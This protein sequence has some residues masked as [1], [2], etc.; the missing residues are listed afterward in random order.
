MRS[1]KR[2]PSAASTPSPQ[3]RQQQTNTN[4]RRPPSTPSSRAAKNK[5][6]ELGIV[7]YCLDAAHTLAPLSPDAA[8]EV[9]ARD[10]ATVVGESNV[11]VGVAVCDFRVWRVGT[12]RMH[13]LLS[14]R[15]T[16]NL[17]QHVIRGLI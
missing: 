10:W 14:Q 12:P 5:L 6:L 13:R 4:T 15:L 11:R 16:L 7:E 2:S 9:F 1:G 17:Q 8:F 3:R